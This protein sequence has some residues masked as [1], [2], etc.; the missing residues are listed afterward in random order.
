MA[1]RRPGLLIRIQRKTKK[2]NE[3]NWQNVS[4]F[5]TSTFPK[6]QQVTT[7]TET[8][9]CQ[10]PEGNESEQIL[11][12]NRATGSGKQC[13]N[14][15]SNEENWRSTEHAG[16]M[17]HSKRKKNGKRDPMPADADASVTDSVD[18]KEK[19]KWIK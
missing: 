13:G 15:Q 12:N 18:E 16:D 4:K 10:L 11:T 7:R 6:C 5:K 17:E 8:Q 14:A 3:I 19:N 2:N 1:P 9:K